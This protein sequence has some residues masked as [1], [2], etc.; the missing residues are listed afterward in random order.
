[1]RE[2]NTKVTQKPCVKAAKIM[3]EKSPCA[4]FGARVVLMIHFLQ[5]RHST[6][7]HDTD[8]R[9]KTNSIRQLA[10]KNRHKTKKLERI[11]SNTNK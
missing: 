2:L 3:T 10:K 9:T 5:L 4:S 8:S 1:M 6:L 11:R 7:H